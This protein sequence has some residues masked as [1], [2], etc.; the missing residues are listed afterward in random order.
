[1][2]RAEGMLNLPN[3]LS[4]SRIGLA[5]AFVFGSGTTE[6]VALI[7]V[8]SATDFLD[9]W[10]ARRRHMTTRWGA[11]LDPITDRA[12][13]FAAVSSF[14]FRD[15]LTTAQYFT[16]LARDLSTAI[17]FLVARSVSW[18]RP[19]EFRARMPGKIVTVLQLF[20]LLAVLLVPR[21]VSPLVI[22]VGVLSAVAVGDYTLMLWR[23][24]AR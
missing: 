17:G 6:R 9:G 7:G 14:M 1:M 19:V 16:L 5:V 11:L 22:A 12:F 15:E 13:V 24:R 18:L 4:L 10:I 21:A 23:N 20:T 2:Q 3:V 8:A